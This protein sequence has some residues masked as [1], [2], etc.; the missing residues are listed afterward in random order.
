MASEGKIYEYWQAQPC[1][2]DTAKSQPGT[3]EYYDEIE[4]SRYRLEPFI[5]DF[6]DFPRW[7][8]QRVLEIGVGIGTDVINFARAGALLTGVDLTPAAVQHTHKRLE[9]EGLNA[10]VLVANGEALPFEN[11]SFDLVYSWGVIH[12]ASNPPRVVREVRRV[13]APGGQA[14]VMLYGRHSWIAYWLWLRHALAAGRPQ[15]SLS[16]VIAST[17]ESEG[18]A[19]YTRKGIERLFAAAGFDT[20][21]VQGF[22]TPYDRDIAGPLA[23]LVRRDWFLGVIAS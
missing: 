10:E 17:V 9:L 7:H 8:A 3:R 21:A 6:A 11:D 1:G 4:K 18:T 12:H 14:R 15:R 23:R 22:P 13:L 2:T 20:V 16:D 19:A 5:P